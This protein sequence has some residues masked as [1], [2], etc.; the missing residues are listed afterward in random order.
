MKLR[1]VFK[2]GYYLLYTQEDPDKRPKMASFLIM[3]NAEL[4]IKLPSP[5][6]LPT[7]PYKQDIPEVSP[8][9]RIVIKDVIKELSP[10]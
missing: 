9:T 6:C 8:S 2:L 4:D 10:R 7:F 3:L 5:D 1:D